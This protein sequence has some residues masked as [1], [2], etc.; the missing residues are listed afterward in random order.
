VGRR[1]VRIAIGAASRTKRLEIDG[2]DD[3]AII[4]AVSAANPAPA[5]LKRRHAV[6][7]GVPV[8]LIASPTR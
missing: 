3:A 7:D 4:E 5:G 8:A 1:D 6:G 2:L